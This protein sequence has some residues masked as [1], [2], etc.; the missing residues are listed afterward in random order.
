MSKQI[1]TQA[2]PAAASPL[3][4]QD[5]A[6]QVYVGVAGWTCPGRAD[7]TFPS[8]GSHLARYASVLRAVE[9]NS[10]FYRMHRRATYERWRKSVPDGFRFTLKV[11]K[12]I[13]HIRRLVDC[14]ELLQVFLGASAGLAEKRAVILVQL[15][16]SFRFDCDLA[17]SFFANVRRSYR[18]GIACEPRH[19]SWFTPEAEAVLRDARVARVA[20]DPGVVAEAFK[21]GGWTDLAYYRLHGSP[22]TY[23]SSYN[24]SQLATLADALREGSQGTAFCIFDNTAAGA[25]IPNALTFAPLVTA[26]S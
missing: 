2:S 1:D 13:T 23:Y 25:A 4:R 21:P 18:G 7:G 15:P 6:P 17:A 20:A 12:E 3:S 26:Q 24:D 5:S 16:P 10:S 14:D 9:I 8:E 11:P 19:E 22:R